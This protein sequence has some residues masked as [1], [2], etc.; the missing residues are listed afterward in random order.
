MWLSKALRFHQWVPSGGELSNFWIHSLKNTDMLSTA[1]SDCAWVGRRSEGRSWRNHAVNET[2]TVLRKA[3]KHV[4]AWMTWEPSHL[5]WAL[6]S[7]FG[8]DR[9]VSA[10]CF[11]HY[12]TSTSVLT[13][14]T[15]TSLSL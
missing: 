13:S 6:Y 14:K 15:L 8:R 5:P 7:D 2:N 4:R 10:S 1:P 3:G 11:S 12:F 9:N